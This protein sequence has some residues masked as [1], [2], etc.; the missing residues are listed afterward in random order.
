MPMERKNV[1]KVS[2]SLLAIAASGVVFF[3]MFGPEGCG[4][5]EDERI[6]LA[7]L[8]AL[9]EVVQKGGRVKHVTAMPDEDGDD[10]GNVYRFEAEIFDPQG[11]AIGRLRGG[12]IE[13][14]G[15]MK[16]RFLW[17]K[18]PGVPE[19]WPARPPRGEDRRRGGDRRDRGDRPDRPP[20]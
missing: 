15:T 6:L 20:Q 1:I 14:F 12:R 19:D 5:S 17:Y 8:N 18:T 3:G 2:L 7:T 10:D 9:D 11:V 13:G 4:P 16:P